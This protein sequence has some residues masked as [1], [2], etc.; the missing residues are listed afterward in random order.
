MPAIQAEGLA[1]PTRRGG[2]P[3]LAERDDPA[4][5]MVGLLG[6]S[7]S[8]KTTLFRLL[9]GALRPSSGRL[10]VLG[11]DMGRIRPASYVGCGDDWAWST[12]N[13]TWCHGSR[14]RRTCSGPR[15]A[16]PR[17]GE[18]SLGLVHLTQDRPTRGLPGPR[19]A[20]DRR[21]TLCPRRRPVGGQQQRVAVARALL[22]DPQLL[23]ADE[24][25]ASVDSRTAGL[26]MER[27]QRLNTS[28]AL[29]WWSAC[30]RP[31]SPAATARGSCCWPPVI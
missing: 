29:P 17:S 18:R 1:R 6:A 19:G 13:T 14:P 10:E 3:T 22:Q 24:P 26:I 21:Q 12:N 31:T 25:I 8:G 28:R 4:G 27:F 11:C 5:E 23:L 16:A 9:G 20:G 7:G 2:R 15:S 30:T